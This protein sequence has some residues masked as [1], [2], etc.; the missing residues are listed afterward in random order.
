M[1][2]FDTSVALAELLAEDRHP[3]AAFWDQEL[4]SS[5]VLEYEIWNSI[6]RRQ[7]RDSHG[8]SARQ[9]IESPAI[10]ELSREILRRAVEPF[11]LPVRTLDALHLSALLFL[12]DQGVEIS[13][14]AYDRRM[15]DAAERLGLPLAEI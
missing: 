3:S 8:E 12:R 6:H 9:L 2:Y 14:A 1:I 4:I 7:L 5:R 10:A 11:P 13:L 15:I